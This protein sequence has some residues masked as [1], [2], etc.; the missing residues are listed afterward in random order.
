MFFFPTFTFEISVFF[1]NEFGHKECGN[2]KGFGASAWLL[3]NS[4]DLIA[5]IESA[6]HCSVKSMVL[7]KNKFTYGLLSR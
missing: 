5:E 6:A 7:P 4:T 3:L 1:V 2:P